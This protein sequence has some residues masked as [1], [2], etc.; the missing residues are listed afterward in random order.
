MQCHTPWYCRVEGAGE[1][2]DEVRAGVGVR[3][4]AGPRSGSGG[5][6]RNAHGTRSGARQES[7]RELSSHAAVS[8]AAA[9]RLCGVCA[10]QRSVVWAA[11]PRRWPVN[12]RVGAL[13]RGAPCLRTPCE[14]TAPPPSRAQVRAPT[15]VQGRG[16]RTV[17][18][19]LRHIAR[20]D[21][22]LRHRHGRRHA[23]TA[24]GQRKHNGVWLTS[25]RLRVLITGSTST[26][27]PAPDP[28]GAAA[29]RAEARSA[30]GT[31]PAPGTSS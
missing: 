27:L 1:E 23:A 2:E 5:Q 24:A 8:N 17:L 18:H 25:G 10:S 21:D 11:L 20:L 16:V 29:T 22:A 7:G 13:W 26:R 9:A 14:D 6:G 30:A 15:P 28:G 31:V 3:S 4:A 12:A 19:T